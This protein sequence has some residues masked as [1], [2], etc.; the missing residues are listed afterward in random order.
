MSEV[1]L[2]ATWGTSQAPRRLAATPRSI[3]SRHSSGEKSA[4]STW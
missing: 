2:P 4:W 3:H 1:G